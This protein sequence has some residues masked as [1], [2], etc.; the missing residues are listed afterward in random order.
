MSLLVYL[1]R[2]LLLRV[3]VFPLLTMHKMKTS[4]EIIGILI[5]KRREEK[6]ITQNQL[7]GLLFV[8]R[9]YIWRLENGKINIT[10]NYLDKVIIVLNYTHADFFIKL[11]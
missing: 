10:M 5:K 7:A 8:D 3:F 1:W 2:L 6:N 11:I 9:Q 4:K